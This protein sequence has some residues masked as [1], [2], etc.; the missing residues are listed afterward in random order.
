VITET[1]RVTKRNEVKLD[2]V[3]DATILAKGLELQISRQYQLTGTLE[4]VVPS[5]FK[6]NTNRLL[7]PLLNFDPFCLG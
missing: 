5:Y 7:L 6:L 2:D 1:I 3:I 4:I